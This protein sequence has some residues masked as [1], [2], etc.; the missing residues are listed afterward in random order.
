MEGIDIVPPDDAEEFVPPPKRVLFYTLD[1]K[2]SIVAEA[3]AVGNSIKSTARKWRV[4]PNQIRKWRRQLLEDEPI[5]Q[6]PEPRTIEERTVIKEQKANKTRHKG[7]PFTIDEGILNGLLAF[8]EQ[9]RDEG[10]AV[11]TTLVTV[12]LLRRAPELAAVGFVPLRRRVLRFLKNHHLTFRVVTHKAQNHRYHAAIIADYT[13]YINRQIVAS[14]YGADCILNFDETNID[15]DPSPRST[16][17]K[18]GERSISIRIS[19]HS[20]R[21]TVMSTQFNQRDGWMVQPIKSGYNA[22]WLLMQQL[23]TTKSTYFRICFLST[24][25]TTASLL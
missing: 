24:Y 11:T 15:F 3:Y 17:S 6:Y 10:N 16:L 19:G 1:K 23:I 9:V 25:T 2:R 22:S 14:N 5:P 13:M 12:E 18:V 21:C 20:G 4:Q 8:V 7:R